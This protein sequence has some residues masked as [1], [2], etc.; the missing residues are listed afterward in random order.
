MCILHVEL[1]KHEEELALLK[2]KWEAVIQR[3]MQAAQAAASP[4]TQASSSSAAF[5]SPSSTLSPLPATQ[6]LFSSLTSSLGASAASPAGTS[7]SPKPPS[8]SARRLLTTR[9]SISVASPSKAGNA[10]RTGF[11]GGA[12]LSREDSG[13]STEA[14]SVPEDGT[15]YDVSKMA[16]SWLGG[17]V[18]SASSVLETLAV[19]PP[20]S[21]DLDTVREEEEPE[22]EDGVSTSRTSAGHPSAAHH[23]RKGSAA[24]LGN[25]TSS[26]IGSGSP[27]SSCEEGRFS[28]STSRSSS[29]SSMHSDAALQTGKPGEDITP[30]AT[31]VLDTAQTPKGAS[32]SAEA[33]DLW[34]LSGFE[35]DGAREAR[36]K[37]ERERIDVAHTSPPRPVAAVRSSP[38]QISK[39]A[40]HGRRRSTAF[41]LGGAWG[42]IVGKKWNEV[43]NS[44]V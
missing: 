37:R 30:V 13:S 43:A 5:S 28:T 16:R 26:S 10:A 8:A 35:D 11:L 32:S 24:T 34:G 14:S 22:E 6:G 19:P 17:M 9:H 21:N 7:P 15:A 36:E 44:E 40:S 12:D 20:A 38:A 18:K 33:E 2:K 4:V 39:P 23:D 31:P 27:S 42:S 25:E 29:V 41:E 1:K 3:E